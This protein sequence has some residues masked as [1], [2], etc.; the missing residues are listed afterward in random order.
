MQQC[1]TCNTP[2]PFEFFAVNQSY[3]TGR[4]TECKICAGIKAKERYRCPVKT[5]V[6]KYKIPVDAAK[7]LVFAEACEICGQAQK[8]KKS[9]C[10]DHNHTT[11]KIRGALCDL[12][13]KGLGQFRDNRELLLKAEKYLEKHANN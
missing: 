4:A 12:C 13:N 2:K 10:I 11:G 9:M 1:R 7:A 3:K 6:W 5:A 8:T